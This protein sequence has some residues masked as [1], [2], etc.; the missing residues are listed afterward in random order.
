MIREGYINCANLPSMLVITVAT[1]VTIVIYYLSGKRKATDLSLDRDGCSSTKSR[2]SYKSD[3]VWQ[4]MTM[5]RGIR[6][7][8]VDAVVIVSNSSE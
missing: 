3:R 4:Q 2:H 6:N 1:T 8:K 5:A 7:R